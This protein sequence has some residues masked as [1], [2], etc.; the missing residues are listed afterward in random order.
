MLAS[1][2]LRIPAVAHKERCNR[3]GLIL[4]VLAMARGKGKIFV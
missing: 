1:T 3:D 2:D 4:E